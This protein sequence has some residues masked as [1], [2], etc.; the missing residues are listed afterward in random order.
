MTNH[1]NQE[2]YDLEGVAYECLK[3]FVERRLDYYQN[4]FDGDVIC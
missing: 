3:N 4:Y 1:S 2:T